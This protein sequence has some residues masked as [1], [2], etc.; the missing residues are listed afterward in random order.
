[1]SGF[2]NPD[3]VELYAWHREGGI[4]NKHYVTC[5]AKN[6]PARASAKPSVDDAALA[7]QACGPAVSIIRPGRPAQCAKRELGRA[8]AIMPSQRGSA[9][10]A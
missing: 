2:V 6:S 3:S 4:T 5:A 10:R 7:D 9:A 8:S 1:M